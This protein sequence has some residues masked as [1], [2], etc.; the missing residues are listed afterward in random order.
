MTFGLVLSKVPKETW[1]FYRTL[2]RYNSPLYM[3]V[4]CAAYIYPIRRYGHDM[5]VEPLIG[6]GAAPR[7]DTACRY[8]VNRFG[9]GISVW[10]KYGFHLFLTG[11]MNLHLW[12]DAVFVIH[13]ST[14]RVFWLHC[15]TAAT[16]WL[17]RVRR[18]AVLTYTLAIVTGFLH[19]VLESTAAAEP[20]S[21]LLRAAYVSQ[22]LV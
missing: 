9:H 3:N 7:N 18:L 21:Q 12:I 8:A 14:F 22:T 15:F 13:H 6:F 4:V 1:F 10:L 20:L 19:S 5:A 17:P 16:K 2:H 11:S